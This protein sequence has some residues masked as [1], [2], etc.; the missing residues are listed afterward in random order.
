VVI[1]EKLG[2][3]A[4]TLS[5]TATD[6]ELLANIKATVANVKDASASIKNLTARAE[7]IRLPGEKKIGT[8]NP[9]AIPKKQPVWY[10]PGLTGDFLYDT[11]AERFQL[12]THYAQV[13]QGQLFRVGLTDAGERNRVDLQV[14]QKSGELWTR[15]GLFDRQVGPFQWRLDL[16]DPNRFTANTRLRARLN[17][18]TALTLG[19]DSVGNGNRPVVGIQIRK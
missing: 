14:G 6:P 8:A 3:T 17:T 5:K 7:T 10:E 9:P 18:N 16:L 1:S 19:V 12:D 15:Y 11:K 2:A 4:D 13:F